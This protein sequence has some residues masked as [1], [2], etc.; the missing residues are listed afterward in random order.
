MALVRGCTGRGISRGSR[1]DG[2]LEFLGRGDF[3]VK[4]RG[5]RIELGEIEGRL[6]EHPDVREAVVVARE[7]TPG[8]KRLVAYYTGA[9][10]AEFGA[11]ELRAHLQAVLPEYMVP[12]AYAALEQLPL[13]P[14]GKLDRLLVACARWCGLHGA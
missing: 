7:D 2:T 12:A 10:G 14:N 6:R 13:S 9:E 8:D 4:I 1:N 3:Q 5:F 11:S